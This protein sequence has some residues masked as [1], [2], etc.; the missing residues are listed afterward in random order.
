MINTMKKNS[1]IKLSAAIAV[2]F[3][4]FQAPAKNNLPVKEI[5]NFVEVFNLL[6]T[7][8]VD[9]KNSAELIDN[10][11]SGMLSG[12]DPHSAYIKKT[13][14]EDF[15]ND[16]NGQ[17][18]GLGVELDVVDG[19][20]IVVSPITNSPA[21]KAGVKAGDNIVKIDDKVIR[22][23][24]M[25]DISNLIRKSK[26]ETINLVIKRKGEK[27]LKISVTKGKVSLTSIYSKLLDDKFAH[28][29]ISQFQSDTAKDFIAEV[30]KLQKETKLEGIIIDLRNNPGGLVTSA[31]K[32]A[33]YFLKSGLIVRTKNNN[34][35][36]ESKINATDKQYNKIPLVV[37]INKGSASASELLA[38][39]LQD[40]KRAIIVGQKSFGKGS[41]QN[42]IP[43]S[44]GDIVKIT[45]A[46]YYTPNN[47]SIQA[48][49]ITPDITLADLEVKKSEVELLAYKEKDIDNH[50]KSDKKAQNK[51]VSF[52]ST[53]VA[54]TDFQLFEALN[55]MKTINFS[56]N[57]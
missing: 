42:I 50:I 23:M 48:K 26:T 37:L 29:F 21:E 33:D 22:N 41:V 32:I 15:N 10:A 27:T 2:S 54:K 46:K 47:V 30:N 13:K 34:S 17:Y 52:S 8:Y 3:L 4:S 16:I 5:Q 45:T 51:T 9:E 24:Q 7:Q 1:I 18:T 57:K 55:I 44:N 19:N 6:K 12:L 39:A 36:L 56:K 31:T 43:L 40:H 28:I 35:G 20:L 14:K 25:H 53:Q 38:G 11:I 49:G